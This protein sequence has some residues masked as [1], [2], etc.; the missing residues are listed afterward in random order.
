MRKVGWLLGILLGI[1]LFLKLER[2][3]IS[4]KPLIL[5]MVAGA[6]LNHL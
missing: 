1:V 5:F 4:S 6:D 2:L 3:R